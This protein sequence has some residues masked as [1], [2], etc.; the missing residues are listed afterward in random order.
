MFSQYRG[1]KAF[2]MLMDALLPVVVLA[3]MVKLRPYLPGKFLDVGYVLPSPAVYLVVALIWHVTFA[4]TGVYSAHKIPSFSNQIGSVTLAQGLAFLTL[5]GVL[6]FSFRETS[7]MLVIYH[8]AATY[9]ALLLVRYGLTMYLSHMVNGNRRNRV[10][11]VGVSR[12]ALSIAET[13]NDNH[14]R[15]MEVIGFVDGRPSDAALPAPFLGGTDEMARTVREN[16]V[17]TVVVALSRDQA[18]ELESIIYQLDS[19]PVRVYLVPDFLQMS[20]VNA[21][22]ERF[23]DL[24]VIGIRE[25]MIQGHR[26]VTKRVMD[27]VLSS[28]GIVLLSPLMVL[29][30]I[31]VRLDS[32][33]PGIFVTERIGENGTIF[34]MYKFRTMVQDAQDLL[35]AALE[36]EVDGGTV[37]KVKDDPRVTRLGKWLRRTSLDELPQL[38]N[39][40]KGEMSLVGPRPEQPFITKTYD[41]WQ[42][43]RLSVPPGLTGW[44]QVSGRSDAP[45]NLNTH[46]DIYY[47]RNYSLILDLKIL[48]KTLGTVI[49]GK[50]A[51]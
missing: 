10:L 8:S 44:W 2:L 41:H 38:V 45:M 48:L 47:V 23:G 25:P 46:F 28:I 13:I 7:R 1:Y 11:I 35:G 5:A 43:E 40:L 22:A 42:W 24:I 32:R 27:I 30:W 16:R 50:G 17:E 20:F 4:I 39:I 36:Q 33:G 18:H 14:G 29:I 34:R 3:L 15:F 12:V 37:Y 49:S 6:Y 51:Y 21:S 9:A 19:L 31:A 26:R